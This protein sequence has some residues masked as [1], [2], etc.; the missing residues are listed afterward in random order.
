MHTSSSPTLP[1]RQGVVAWSPD[2]R[3]LLFSG[4]SPEGSGLMLTDAS[5]AEPQPLDAI[6]EDILLWVRRRRVLA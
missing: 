5:G 6:C 4:D 2:G 1:A 3:Q